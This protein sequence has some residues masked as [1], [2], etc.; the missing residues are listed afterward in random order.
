MA[1]GLITPT[2]IQ[3]PNLAGSIIEGYT[4]GQ[5]LQL[6]QLQMQGLQQEQAQ[7]QA[8]NQLI[9]LAATTQDP[10]LINKIALFNPEAAKAFQD[11][12]DKKII[13]AGQ[14][15]QAV[16][17]THATYRPIAYENARRQAELEGLDVSHLPDKYDPNVDDDLDFI[18]NSARDIEKVLED[19]KREADIANVKSQTAKNYADIGKIKADTLEKERDLA[20]GK[21]MSGEGAKISTIADGG[22]SAVNGIRKLFENN[23][24]NVLAGETVLPNWM[25]G[26]KA[27][28]YN[29]LRTDLG[30]LLGRLRSGGQITGTEEA[31][32]RKLIPAFGDKNPEVKLKRL[33]EIFTG[34]NKKLTGRSSTKMTEADPLGIL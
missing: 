3:S 14:L 33:E 10:A 16:K 20:G 17:K 22:I 31:N 30:D 13:R 6:R 5:N 4:Q 9:N 28:E 2:Q 1:D 8:Q 27:Q 12:L 23:N 34:L 15:A 11:R 21:P 24:A 26:E 32:Y 7:K 19:P 29:V 25:Q 18:I